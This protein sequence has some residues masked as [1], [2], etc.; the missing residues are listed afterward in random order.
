MVYSTYL[1]GSFADYGNS[2]AV[3][4]SRNACVTG[5]TLS[6]D[7]PT[8]N[9]VQG[10]F[11]GGSD[12]V[13]AKISPVDAPGLGLSVQTLSFSAAVGTSTSQILT[14]RSVGSKSLLLRWILALE[15]RSV[16][17]QTNN[18]ASALSPGETCTITVTFRPKRVGLQRGFLLIVD[19]AYP[20]P[21]TLFRMTRTGQ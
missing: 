2:I 11:H 12:A 1:G 14:L 4:G 15:P 10:N 20:R 9:P 21:A 5:V 19:N 6:T 18:C 7:F 3:D 16:F 13:V 17:A 8:V